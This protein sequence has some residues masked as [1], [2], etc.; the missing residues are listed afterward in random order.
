MTCR[1]IGVQTIYI[2]KPTECNGGLWKATVPGPTSHAIGSPYS[3]LVEI[4]SAIVFCL[5]H[6]KNHF[7]MWNISGKIAHCFLRNWNENSTSHRPG[8]AIVHS[9]AVLFW[10]WSASR[11]YGGRKIPCDNF[12]GHCRYQVTTCHAKIAFINQSSWS[13]RL[14]RTTFTAICWL[15][16]GRHWGVLWWSAPVE[17]FAVWSQF[18]GGCIWCFGLE[19]LCWTTWIA[20]GS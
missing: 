12:K 15:G 16:V 3:F 18:E 7:I 8:F 2:D 4:Q 19:T 6:W 10:P 20:W 9:S 14:V 17:V 5:A 11:G 13:V 1:A